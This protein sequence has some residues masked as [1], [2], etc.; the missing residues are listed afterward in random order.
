MMSQYAFFYFMKPNP[1]GIGE[2]ISDHIRYWNSNKPCD[3]S[4]G[5]FSD[6]SGGLILFK[7]ENIETAN[8]LIKNDPFVIGD[9]IEKKWVKEWMQKP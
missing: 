3:Y 6:Q 4:G 7:V 9:V 1:S 8:E 2:L 5:P